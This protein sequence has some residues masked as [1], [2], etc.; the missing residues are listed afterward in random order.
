MVK[1]L[2]TKCTEILDATAAYEFSGLIETC[3]G[4]Y[5][6]YAHGPG[7]SYVAYL[8]FILDALNIN[9]VDFNRKRDYYYNILSKPGTI[10]F[11]EVD[12]NLR[13]VSIK[14]VEQGSEV[15]KIYIIALLLS[16]QNICSQFI[17]EELEQSY[18]H[19]S[20][21]KYI[22]DIPDPPTFLVTLSR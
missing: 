20:T 5:G 3:P 16:T 12:T 7:G 13:L 14:F 2:Q 18:S 21:F 15:L 4:F 17:M 1:L 9:N 10:R 22:T 19:V 6:H 8:K 11:G